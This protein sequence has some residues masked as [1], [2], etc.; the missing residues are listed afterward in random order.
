MKRFA[1]VFL[2]LFA[3]ILACA[4]ATPEQVVKKM[5]DGAQ[6]DD[7]NAIVSCMSAEA[8][9]ELDESLIQ[10]KEV[11]EESAEFLAMLGVE[12]TAEEITNMTAGDFITALL[13]S[14]VIA[15]EM[16]DFSP[17]V[18]GETIIEGE[19]AMVEVTIDGDT[20]EFELILQDGE[21]KLEEGL[22]FM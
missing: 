18:I 16:P 20:N 1:V 12:M 15:E 6:N 22:D 9:Q 17:A 10:L 2:A 21:W 5:I 7:G 8:V 13:S 14:E 4:G 11:P 3:L 19:K